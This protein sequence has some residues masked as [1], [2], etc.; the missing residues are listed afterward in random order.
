MT[1]V[2][3]AGVLVPQ[4]LG[5]TQYF[6]KAREAFPDAQFP[7]V[8][9]LAAISDRADALASQLINC[10]GPIHIIA[11][12]MA[13][14][15]ARHLLSHDLRGLASS[16]RVASLSMIATPNLGS[17]IA[18]V[19]AGPKP[20]VVDVPL[21]ILFNT[22]VDLAAKIGFSLAAANNLTGQYLTHTF[23]PQTPNVRGVNYQCYTGSGLES[24]L[25]TPFRDHI[26]SVGGTPDEKANDGLVSVKSASWT[27]LAEPAWNA[28]DHVSEIGHTLNPPSFTSAFDHIAAY[29]RILARVGVS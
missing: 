3:A 21:W 17:P 7:E 5:V 10:A 28:A 23:N 26:A 11:H 24:L 1:V 29:R 6:R 2:F 15:D 22:L 14:L 18:D 9:T 13:G 8:P 19:L 4:N 16:G 20:S 27:P 25:L 12:S